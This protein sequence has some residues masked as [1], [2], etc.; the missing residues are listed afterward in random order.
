MERRSA[1][2]NEKVSLELLRFRDRI[3]CR[4]ALVE[5]RLTNADQTID[6]A[7][8]A[9]DTEALFVAV[10]AKMFSLSEIGDTA[11]IPTHFA[12]LQ[13]AATLADR[14]KYRVVLLSMRA[15]VPCVKANST[16]LRPLPR[17]W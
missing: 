6:L 14:P 2:R 1:R 9:G 15:L 12:L 13:Q 17:S 3:L 8:K 11:S 7:R 16:W 10:V 4:P 5:Q